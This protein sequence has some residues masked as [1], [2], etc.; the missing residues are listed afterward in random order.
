MTAVETQVNNATSHIN[1][2]TFNFTLLNTALFDYQ[3]ASNA[4]IKEK[5]ATLQAEL[6]KKATNGHI[7]PDNIY[8]FTV[9]FLL[10]LGIVNVVDIALRLIKYAINQQVNHVAYGNE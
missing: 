3:N 4:T 9:L 7:I 10:A 8:E 5:V 6:D 2:S 1:T